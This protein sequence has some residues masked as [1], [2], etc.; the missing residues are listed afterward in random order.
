MEKARTSR[1]GKKHYSKGAT[2]GRKEGLENVV[3]AEKKK[4]FVLFFDF[5]PCFGYL[6]PQFSLYF[7]K[8][9]M[10]VHPV[11]IKIKNV[12]TFLL[13]AKN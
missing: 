12:N 1:L 8:N 7:K 11:F 5:C 10:Y 13:E 4:H 9:I 2:S 6:N 3:G